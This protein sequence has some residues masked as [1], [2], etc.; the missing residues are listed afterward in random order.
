MAS[1]VPTQIAERRV[2]NLLVAFVVSSFRLCFSWSQRLAGRR[3]TQPHTHGKCKQ[4]G[5]T[6]S[7]VTLLFCRRAQLEAFLPHGLP[8]NPSTLT[9]QRAHQAQ[10]SGLRLLFAVGHFLYV[11]FFTWCTALKVHAPSLHALTPAR[12]A[13]Q[14]RVGKVI[15]SHCFVQVDF[16]AHL[17]SGTFCQSTGSL[18][19]EVFMSYWSRRVVHS[20]R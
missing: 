17:F 6:R 10:A 20:A 1:P 11:C 13:L 12:G 7:A 5:V 4:G 18:P 3:L 9:E 16:A 14:W 2:R 8:H 19:R 15:I